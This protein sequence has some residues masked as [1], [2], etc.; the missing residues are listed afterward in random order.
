[1]IPIYIFTIEKTKENKKYEP[2]YIGKYRM[3]RLVEYICMFIGFFLMIIKNHFY[4]H[5]MI[6]NCFNPFFITFLNGFF[7]LIIT[8]I[9][10]YF[11]GYNYNFS[12]LIGNII[13]YILYIFVLFLYFIF[14]YLS[15]YYISPT[16]CGLTFLFSNLFISLVEKTNISLFGIITLESIWIIPLFLPTIF[17]SILYCEFIVFHFWSLDQQTKFVIEERG[18]IEDINTNKSV[19]SITYSIDDILEEK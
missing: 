17:M 11:L 6:I 8:I 15:N 14:Q 19:S 5:F 2:I 18:K 12:L 13:I 9:G 3:Y 7:S 1:M 4:N 16:S 10:L